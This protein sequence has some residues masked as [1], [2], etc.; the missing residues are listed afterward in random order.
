MRRRCALLLLLFSLCGASALAQS[1]EVVDVVLPESPQAR[2]GQRVVV[3]LKVRLRNTT[4]G[5]VSGSIQARREVGDPF[6]LPF[7]LRARQT[8]VLA[9][10]VAVDLRSAEV[11]NEYRVILD[12]VTDRGGIEQTRVVDIPVQPPRRVRPRPAQP[13]PPR[14]RV[15]DQQIPRPETNETFNVEPLGTPSLGLVSAAIL[16]PITPVSVTASSTPEAP[17][18]FGGA[19]LPGQTPR[20]ASPSPA[21]PIT[22]EAPDFIGG[23]DVVVLVQNKGF[24]ARRDRFEVEANLEIKGRSYSVGGRHDA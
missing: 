5:V 7:R 6:R 9:L 17:P 22:P 12:V 4:S 13:Q 3:S 14:P 19:M 1:I 18:R 11:G 21:L 8:T 20:P 10:P 2:P 15:S 24:I 16:A 23:F